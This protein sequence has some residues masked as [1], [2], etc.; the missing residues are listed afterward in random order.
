MPFEFILIVIASVPFYVAISSLVE[1]RQLAR[2]DLDAAPIVAVRQITDRAALQRMQRLPS[3][4]TAADAPALMPKAPPQPTPLPTLVLT[5]PVEQ[6]VKPVTRLDAILP[7][8]P[9]H[10][11]QFDPDQDVLVVLYS[12]FIAP[13]PVHQMLDD[14]GLTIRFSDGAEVFLS[15]VSRELVAMDFAFQSSLS[16]TS[17]Q[18]RPAA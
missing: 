7:A 10:L 12:G 8:G 6:P 4:R 1:D 2:E 13:R 14:V 15:G 9:A 17:R 3:S 5:N 11:T 18:L 16:L